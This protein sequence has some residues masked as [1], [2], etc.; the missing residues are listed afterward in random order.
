MSVVY[1]NPTLA[2]HVP[3]HIGVGQVTV[4]RRTFD[5]AAAAGHRP[6]SLVSTNDIVLF[7]VPAGF[8]LIPHLCRFSFPIIDSN[9]T[10]T[11]QASIGVTGNL[12]GIRPAAAL[13]VAR[14]DTG[15]DLLQPAGPIG[16]PINDVD[17][18]LRF[19]ANV[20]T[21]AATGQIICDFAYRPYRTDIDG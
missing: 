2:Q 3:T 14:I 7:R 17:V 19:T 18:L 13:N 6:P 16:N 8:A 9:G 20:A 12:A 21:I 15:E 5:L 1:Q 4:D 10:P 11:G